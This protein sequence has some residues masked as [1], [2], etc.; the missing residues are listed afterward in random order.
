MLILLHKTLNQ[1]GADE[2]LRGIGLL[3]HLEAIKKKNA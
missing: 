3:G 1:L 2:V